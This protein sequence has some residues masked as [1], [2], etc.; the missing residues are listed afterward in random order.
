VLFNLYRATYALLT[1]ILVVCTAGLLATTVHVTT[2]SLATTVIKSTSQSTDDTSSTHA[3]QV[4]ADT[5]V[6]RATANFYKHLIR[7]VEPDDVS[8]C[9]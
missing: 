9:G 4:D 2:T 1:Y 7:V 3:D 5:G 6:Y 8:V